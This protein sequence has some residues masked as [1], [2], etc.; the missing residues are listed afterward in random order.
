MKILLIYPYFI[1]E[2]MHDEDIKAVPMGLYSVGAVLKDNH[3]DVE[4]LDWHEVNRIPEKVKKALSEKKPD[5]LGV[6]W[7]CGN[8]WGAIEIARTDKR[9]NPKVKTVFGG[10]GAT[11][12]WEHLLGNFL[13]VDYVVLGEGEWTFLSLVRH[14]EK[15]QDQGIA[16]TRGIG[17]RQNGKIFKTGEPDP[18]GDLDSLPIP[19]KHFPY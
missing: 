5:V 6:S 7:L 16:E 11:F 4:I 12:L 9:L 15:K 14:F 3:Y 10:I 19:A 1:E 17:A 2:R 18:I 8:R 13:E